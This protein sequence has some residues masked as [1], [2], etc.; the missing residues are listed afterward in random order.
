MVTASGTYCQ[1]AFPICPQAYPQA[2][3]EFSAKFDAVISYESIA[4]A[5]RARTPHTNEETGRRL[6]FRADLLHQ[7]VFQIPA[8]VHGS[9]EQGNRLVQ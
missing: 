4:A 7:A 3:T 8:R 5:L 9:P 6:G 2:H 1:L